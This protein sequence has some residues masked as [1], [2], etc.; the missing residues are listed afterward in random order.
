[1]TSNKYNG[2]R[3]EKARNA[4]LAR[5]RVCQDCGTGDNL[6]VHHIRPVRTF[7]DYGEAHDLNNLVVLCQHCHPEW[8]GRRDRPNA[9]DDGGRVQLS[10]LVH[11][12]S[13]ETIGRLYDEPGPWVLY[14]YFRDVLVD[15]RWRCGVC[16]R[17]MDQTQAKA[18]FCPHCGRGPHFWDLEDAFSLEQ[19]KHR[20]ELVAAALNRH[21][22]P[23]DADVAL[24][25]TEKLWE[26]KAYHDNG[27]LDK[28]LLY[29]VAYVAIQVAYSPAAVG[30]EYDPICPE[31]SPIKTTD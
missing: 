12:L 31:P 9:L 13:R 10:Q 23:A 22:I 21:G 30:V 15:D 7:D 17:K 18:E 16:F 20:S 27:W 4:A 29:N 28:K 1:M 8:E 19:L 11:D 2:E 5:D 3:W 25:M 14:E 26:K 24:S 6:H